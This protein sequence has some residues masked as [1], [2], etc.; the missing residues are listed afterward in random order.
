MIQWLG[1]LVDLSEDPRFL[2][3]NLGSSQP[4][5]S[6]TVGNL[7]PPAFVDT[8]LPIQTYT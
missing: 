6:P 2:V 7:M 3:P 4:P 8:A 1:M 5:V